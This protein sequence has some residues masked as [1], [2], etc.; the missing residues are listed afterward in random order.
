MKINGKSLILI[1]AAATI[2]FLCPPALAADGTVAGTISLEM[3]DGRVEPGAWIRI[4]LVT[5]AVAVPEMSVD[6]KAGH[7]DYVDAVNAL[8]SG[9]YIQ[10]QNRLAE[11]GYLYASTLTTDDGAFKIPAVVPGDY[12]ILVKFPGNIRGYKVAWQ[13]P[14]T[15]IAGE[16]IIINLDRSNLALPT[17]KR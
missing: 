12:F 1:A 5:Q 15:V 7:P 14:V 17:A 6:L 8:H 11:N 9:L 16:T 4:L 3:E 13:V 2:L 10:V